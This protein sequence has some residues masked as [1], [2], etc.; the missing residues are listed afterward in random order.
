MRLSPIA[1]GGVLEVVGLT[2]RV[3]VRHSKSGEACRSSATGT[4]RGSPNRYHAGTIARSRRR[5]IAPV[6]SRTLAKSNTRAFALLRHASP[7]LLASSDR[8]S[9]KRLYETRLVLHWCTAAPVHGRTIA[10]VHS[11]DIAIVHL[12]NEHARACDQHDPSSPFRLARGWPDLLAPTVSTAGNRTVTEQD[13]TQSP[14]SCVTFW[15][16]ERG[17]V[18]IRVSYSTHR[19]A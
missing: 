17:R 4:G 5:T 16:P 1:G 9:T 3:G 12:C 18:Q 13:V 8:A 7:P 11:C 6:H 15:S 2:D 19:R 14:G 10:G